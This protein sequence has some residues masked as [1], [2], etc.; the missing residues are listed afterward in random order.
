MY[1]K[2]AMRY[3]NIREHF[4]E[5]NE[6]ERMNNKSEDE[7]YNELIDNL[8]EALKILADK[9]KPKVFEYGFL[10]K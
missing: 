8:R 6:K 7:H 4:Q 2:T 5:R 10:K 9:I 3:N 1:K